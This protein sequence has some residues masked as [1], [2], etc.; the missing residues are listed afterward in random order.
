MTQIIDNVPVSALIEWS[1]TDP[2]TPVGYFP[3]GSS[4]WLRDARCWD[5]I[6]EDP[7]SRKLIIP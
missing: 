1:F 5:G 4:V 7:Y 3:F 2:S 6:G